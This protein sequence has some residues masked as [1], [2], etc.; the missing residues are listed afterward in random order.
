M[1]TFS[2]EELELK[3]TDIQKDL[4]D[5]TKAMEQWEEIR[6]SINEDVS[7]LK[8]ELNHLEYLLERGLY[9]ERERKGSAKGKRTSEKKNKKKGRI[10]KI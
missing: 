4:S 10:N 9:D 8:D 3:I 5:T 6:D 7:A 1:K 2:K